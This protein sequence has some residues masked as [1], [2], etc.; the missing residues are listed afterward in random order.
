MP[1]ATLTITETELIKKLQK[2]NIDRAQQK[3]LKVLMPEMNQA[4]RRELM[5]LI[6]RSRS[7]M[8]K[9]E[10]TTLK[11]VLILIILF[12]TAGIALY[13]INYFSLV[14]NF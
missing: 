5:E 13:A 6:E 11:I 12:L 3:E 8:K 9:K 2:S 4:E 14:P 7:E 10:R 1:T